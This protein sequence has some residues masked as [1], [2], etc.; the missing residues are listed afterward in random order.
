MDARLAKIRELTTRHKVDTDELSGLLA[1]LNARIEELQET[2]ESID[3][4]GKRAERA[5]AAYF[6]VA[7]SLSAARSASAASLGEAVT[8]QIVELGLLNGHFRIV[9]EAKP[10]DTSRCEWTGSHRVS[11]C[12]KPRTSVRATFKGRIRRGTV[13]R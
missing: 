5:G 1:G 4:L 3:A 8:N 9:V 12:A 10:K 6:K 7:D 11:S 2:S 13:A